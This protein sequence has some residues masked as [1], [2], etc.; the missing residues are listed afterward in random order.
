MYFTYFTPFGLE[1]SEMGEIARRSE[2]GIA[3]SE[4]LSR[5]SCAQT[6]GL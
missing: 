1:R 6:R 5:N 2:N 3:A 4:E